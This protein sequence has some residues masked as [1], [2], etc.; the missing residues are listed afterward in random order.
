[1]GTL[2]W[3]NNYV[4]LFPIPYMSDTCQ[5]A[6]VS[7]V[8]AILVVKE[9]DH[10]ADTSAL[11]SQIDQLVYKLYG[12]TEDEIAI[13]EG[14]DKP[15]AEPQAKKQRR[16]KRPVATETLADEDDEVLE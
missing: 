11:E 12:L 16:A 3:I 15:A 9:R 1:M 8:D 10:K 2:R 6:L 13:V 4:K 5:Q 7:L 14:R